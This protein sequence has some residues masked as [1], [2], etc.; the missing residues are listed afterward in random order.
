LLVP[1]GYLDWEKAGIGRNLLFLFLTGL[2]SILILF[3]FEAKI[4]EKIRFRKNT[5]VA[6]ASNKGIPKDKA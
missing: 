1:R 5:Q 3:I 6:A 2:L 4:Y